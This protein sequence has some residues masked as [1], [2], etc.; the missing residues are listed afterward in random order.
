MVLGT[1]S[2]KREEKLL[3]IVVP[4]TGFEM[5]TFDAKTADSPATKAPTSSRW[6]AKHL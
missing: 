2:P 3:E 4:D 1:E 5:T 6:T